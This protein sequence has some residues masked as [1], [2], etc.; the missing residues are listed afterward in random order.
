[1]KNIRTLCGEYNEEDVYNMDETG[2]F[3]RR[4]PST[5]LS[6]NNL[7]GIKKDKTRITLV[8][9]VNCTGAD[10]LPLWIIG[11]SKVPR[12]LRGLNI[13]ALGGVWTS[14]KKSWMT[15]L[16]MKDW[17]LAFYAHI[18]CQRSVLLLMDNFPAHLGG[19]ELVPPPTNI[20]VQWLPS[21]STVTGS[22]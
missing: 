15:S 7:P 19:V 5:G 2:L 21:N 9:C 4:A 6:S 1:M 16:I 11:K 10:R 13:Q 20:R 3:W 18:G 8:A 14:N 22:E 17:L 12:S